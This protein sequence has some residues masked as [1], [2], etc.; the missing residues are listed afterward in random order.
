M[1]LTSQFKVLIVDDD[2]DDQFLI[3]EAFQTGELQCHLLFANDGRQALQLLDEGSSYLP[4]LIVLDLNMPVMNGFE[5]L[6]RLKVSDLFPRIPVIVMTTSSE[7]DYIDKSYDLGARSFIV[8]PK[9]FK[10]LLIIA[11]N[12]KSYWFKTVSLARVK[13]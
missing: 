3:K 6:S 2:L 11:D 13:K 8:K 7:A 1:I 12:L 4:D 5:V 9:S 10:E